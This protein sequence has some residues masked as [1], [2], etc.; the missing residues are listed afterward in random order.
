MDLE[1]FTFQKFFDVGL[2]KF[3][4]NQILLCK[5]SH[6]FLGTT[7][8]L[9]SERSSLWNK[10]NTLKSEESIPNVICGPSNGGEKE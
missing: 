6:G 3:E 9:M 4:N 8:Y 1:T 2:A 5:V 7:N 10:F